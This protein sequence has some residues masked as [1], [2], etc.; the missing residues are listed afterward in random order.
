MCQHFLCKSSVTFVATQETFNPAN[1][2]TVSSGYLLSQVGWYYILF[3]SQST[4]I[5]FSILLSSL[6]VMFLSRVKGRYFLGYTFCLHHHMIALTLHPIKAIKY[7]CQ[8][9]LW[10]VMVSRFNSLAPGWFKWNFDQAVFKLI[11]VT[12]GWG[13]SCETTLRWM[14]LDLIDDNSTLI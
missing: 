8:M 11:L 9:V 14:S 2:F 3:L 10:S 12:G 7:H 13:I 6:G 4:T 5:L 1:I